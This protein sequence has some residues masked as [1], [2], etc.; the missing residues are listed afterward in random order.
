LSVENSIAANTQ[1][2][3]AMENMWAFIKVYVFF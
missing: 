1:I 2:C 3:Y